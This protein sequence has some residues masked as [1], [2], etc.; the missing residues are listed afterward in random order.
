M[1]LRSQSNP[2]FCDESVLR[3]SYSPEYPIARDELIHK[4]QRVLGRPFRG[5]PPTNLF[6]TGDRGVGKTLLA[7]HVLNQLSSVEGFVG[8]IHTV[9]FPSL[10]EP[11][12]HATAKHIVETLQDRRDCDDSFD[13]QGH[14]AT[15]VF[16]VLVNEL[17]RLEGVVIFVFDDVESPEEASDF[18]GKFT[19][20]FESLYPDTVG[21]F[22]TISRSPEALDG[23]EQSLRDQL[24]ETHLHVPDYTRSQVKEILQDYAELGFKEDVLQPDALSRCVELVVEYSNSIGKGKLLLYNAGEEALAEGDSHISVDHVMKAKKR[25]NQL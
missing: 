20:Y 2:I 24:R 12:N 22:L 7:N 11:T 16:E 13:A 3:D 9:F 15:K 19:A 1:S 6:V 5:D 21:I 17:S 4:F 23:F 10:K 18:F 25:Q 8:P 14:S